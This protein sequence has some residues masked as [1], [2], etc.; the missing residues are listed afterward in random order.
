MLMKHTILPMLSLI[1]GVVAC[2]SARDVDASSGST[3]QNQSTVVRPFAIAKCVSSEAEIG[4]NRKTI[5]LT[6]SMEGNKLATLTGIYFEGSDGESSET[7]LEANI[8]M[9]AKG[10]SGEYLISMDNGLFFFSDD[11]EGGERTVQTKMI[12]LDTTNSRVDTGSSLGSVG[13]CTFSN[14][15][16]LDKFVH[17]D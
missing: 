14:L 16:L 4:A 12:T 8:A 11:S 7:G 13:V 3:A 9:I 5:T 10:P 15:S 1:G 6:A 2:N 17:N